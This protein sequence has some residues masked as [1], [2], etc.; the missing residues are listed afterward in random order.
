MKRLSIALSLFI[1]MLFSQQLLAQSEISLDT[2][3]DKILIDLK[4]GEQNFHGSYNTWKEMENDKKLRLFLKN[5]MEMDIF[6]VDK[7]ISRFRLKRKSNK[8]CDKTNKEPKEKSKEGFSFSI[9]LN[10]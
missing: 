4:K 1:A 2:N 5:E 7:K 10:L 8:K 9:E 6:N 3:G